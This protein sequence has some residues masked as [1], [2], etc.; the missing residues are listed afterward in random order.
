MNELRHKRW[1]MQ[2]ISI[3]I[4]WFYFT[5]LLATCRFGPVELNWLIFSRTWV[6]N[7]VSATRCGFC[8]GLGDSKIAIF[9]LIFDRA[10]GVSLIAGLRFTDAVV[11]CYV[12]QKKKQKHLDVLRSAIY[13]WRNS[14]K[15]LTKKASKGTFLRLA[16]RVYKIICNSERRICFQQFRLGSWRLI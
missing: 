2:K 9:W 10:L 3:Q 16:L 14:W 8:C 4:F 6:L 13:Y 15:Y 7:G 11:L 5:F 12:M 1:Q